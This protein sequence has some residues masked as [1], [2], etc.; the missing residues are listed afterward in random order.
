MEFHMG[1][2]IC[3]EL[4]A[5]DEQDNRVLKC[6][7]N[8]GNDERK[9]VFVAYQANHMIVASENCPFTCTICVFIRCCLIILYCY[10]C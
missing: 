8:H 3:G 2:T 9:R 7:V 1:I 6:N 5:C 4:K 10:M